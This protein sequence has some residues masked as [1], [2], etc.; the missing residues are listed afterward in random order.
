MLLA[1]ALICAALPFCDAQAAAVVR[2]PDWQ[3]KMTAVH[4]AGPGLVPLFVLGDVNEDG[5]VDKK[6]LELVQG[7]VK[8]GGQPQ[9]SKAISCPVAADLDQDG[10][11]GPRDVASLTEWVRLKVTVPALSYHPALPCNFKRF[12]IAA[13]PSVQRGSTALVRFLDKSLNSKNSTVTIEQG[14]GIVIATDRGYDVTARAT[15]KVGDLI[16][17]KITLPRAQ[18]YYYSLLVVEAPEGISN[19]RPTK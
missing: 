11:I 7:L 13:S 19:E 5:K 4:N 15:A 10:V 17:L 8:R 18:N 3:S 1:P 2:P 6:D 16:V 12:F 14:D 9:A